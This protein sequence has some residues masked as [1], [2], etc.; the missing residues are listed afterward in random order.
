[1]KDQGKVD[2]GPAV[3]RQLR[4]W[5]R[6]GYLDGGTLFPTDQGTPQGGA[7]SPLLANI[8]LHGLEELVRER[9]PKRRVNG[10]VSPPPTLVR[11]ADDFV[12]LHDEECVVRECR[13]VIAGCSSNAI[14]SAAEREP[15]EMTA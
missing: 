1:M 4:A 11:Y 9:F 3:R 6:A 5:L 14:A 13:V 2:A 8:A 7:I 10:T 12:V 15:G